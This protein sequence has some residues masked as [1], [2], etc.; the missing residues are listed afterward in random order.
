MPITLESRHDLTLAAARRVG[1]AG[2]TVAIGASAL[3]RIAEARAAFERLM[4]EPGIVIYGVT[5]GYGQNAWKRFSRE[6][7]KQH[8]L[9]RLHLPQAHF[10]VAFPERVTRLMVLARL[11]NFLEGHA[12]VR[13]QL[14][15]AV[16]AMLAGPLPRVPYEGAVTA[17]EILPLSYLFGPLAEAIVPAEKEV[18]A[19]E[20]G[21]PVAAA[22][23]ADGA[24][25]A[26]GRLTLAEEVLALSAEAYKIPLGHFSPDVSALSGDPH[27]LATA[28]RLASLI[29]GG[30]A[31][32]RPYQAP[33]S[34]RIIPKMLARLRRAVAQAEEA[35]SASLAQVSDNPTFLP[36]DAAH[37]NGR[38]LSTGGYHNALGWPALNALAMAYAD[39]VLI[40]GR[41]IARMLD[42]KTSGLPDQLLTGPDD[43]RYL[44]TLGFAI[45]GFE[46]TARRAA[47]AVQLPGSDHGGFVQ[48]DVSV[49]TVPAW[50]GQE[51]AGRMLDNALASLAVVA[52]HAFDASG[53]TPP[54]GLLPLMASIRS[55]APRLE[56][57]T[58]PGPLAEAVARVFAARVYRA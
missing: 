47:Q 24:L 50:E 22:L 15:E 34:F 4:D 58:A 25:A 39:L 44:G 12:A 28:R 51:T 53:R 36:P 37:P 14:A 9:Q 43:D 20:N 38:I 8:A 30:T 52:A 32:R 29:E 57:S 13:P 41:H 27:E 21:A 40:C 17:G 56:S 19:L 54:P 16:A 45:V 5:S 6:E 49:P 42:G 7:R 23:T 11:A 26:S 2:D 33:V 31:D 10:G 48:N 55:V 3:A 46:E 1:W 35:A 18:L